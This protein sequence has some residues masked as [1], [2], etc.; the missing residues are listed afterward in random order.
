MIVKP[1]S[2]NNRHITRLRRERDQLMAELAE[3]RDDL[4]SVE[5][6][7]RHKQ[8]RLRDL[9]QS[10]ASKTRHASRWY[11]IDATHDPLLSSAS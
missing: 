11:V 7:I 4:Q 2:N 6:I 10:I 9:N 8:S 3:L 5:G 1:I